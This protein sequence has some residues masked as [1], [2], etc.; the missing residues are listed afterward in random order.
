MPYQPT[1]DL[2]LD[3]NHTAPIEDYRRSL[4]LDLA[5]VDISYRCGGYS[6]TRFSEATTG[7]DLKESSLIK[8]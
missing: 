8:D 6:L 4:D 5:H 2:Y 7:S 1:G 3:F